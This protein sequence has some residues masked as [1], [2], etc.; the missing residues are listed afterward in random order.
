MKVF[1]QKFEKNSKNI[2]FQE[3]TPETFLEF[4]NCLKNAIGSL[5]KKMLTDY[6]SV[7]DKNEHSVLVDGKEL[8]FKM[9]SEK[10]FLTFFGEIQ[11]KRCLYQ[12]DRGGDCCIPLDEKWGM[13]NEYAAPDVQEATLYSS[14]HMIPTEAEAL[15]K[16]CSFFDPSAT[17]IMNIVERSANIINQHEEK[18]YKQIQKKEQIPAGTEVLVCSLDGANVLLR[19]KGKKMG[20][21]MQR[22]QKTEKDT[23]KKADCY[24]NAMV[25]TIS[26]Y[27]QRKENEK[28]P[29]R[30]ETKYTARMPEDK[31][32]TFKQQFEKQ[33]KNTLIKSPKEIK[34]LLLLD[35]ARNLWSYVTENDLYDKFDRLIDF[36]H[37]TEHLSK[38]AEVLF[39]KKN[40]KAN[41]WY[42]KYRKILLNDDKGAIKIIRSIEYYMQ[43]KKLSALKQESITKELTFFRRNF[44]KMNYPRFLTNGWPI[45]SGPVEAAC[46]SIVK[47][48]LCRSGMRWTRKGGQAIL[49]LR[50]IIKSN[51]WDSFWDIYQNLKKSA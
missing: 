30:L 13:K 35:G 24:K 37:T 9:K 28:H 10:K 32:V 38:A 20:K 17:A 40:E 15:F 50:T 48:R 14:A 47:T 46:K 1:K 26:F 27:M 39:G 21:K 4:S 45:G 6:I 5:G 44:D 12:H 33:L 36:Y 19:E 18:I 42:N 41:V 51:R 25:G 2:D 8:K 43:Q 7:F 3:L 22:P 29:E 49:N 11:L 31:A 16:K 23:E 34:K